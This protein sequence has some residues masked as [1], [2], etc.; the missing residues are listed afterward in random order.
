MAEI[1]TT[2]ARRTWIERLKFWRAAYRTELW[3]GHQIVVG[4]GPSPE[5]WPERTSQE[6][7]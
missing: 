7:Y 6:T 5:A 2:R 3:H 1:R 4:R